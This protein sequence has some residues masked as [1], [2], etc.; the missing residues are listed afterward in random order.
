MVEGFELHH[1][2]SRCSASPLAE[3]PDLGWWQPV[4]D[5]G[6]LVAGTYLHGLFENG[7]WR[8]RWLNKLRLRR[9]LPPLDEDQPHQLQQRE[10][11][12]DR[13]AEAFRR[14][15]DL[16]PLID[17]PHDACYYPDSGKLAPGGILHLATDWAPY[18]EHMLEVMQG[19]EGF[20]NLSPDGAYCEKPGWRPP[21][22]YERRG[23]RLGHEVAD[24][25]FRRRAGGQD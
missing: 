19:S 2:Q 24:L 13:L 5:R 7:A 10:A 1:G 23:R 21:T 3:D 20:E 16:A 11:L 18:A 9:R 22:K 25:V 15:V 4:G 12:L 6:G 17:P 8:R 14:H